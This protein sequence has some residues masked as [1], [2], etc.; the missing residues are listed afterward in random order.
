MP[1]QWTCIYSRYGSLIF[2]L[3]F[4]PAPPRVK[5][6]FTAWRMWTRPSG[7]DIHT[8][9]P[10]ALV[11]KQNKL[12][13]FS[14]MTTLFFVKTFTCDLE[15]FHG[16]NQKY[17]NKQKTYYFNQYIGL[18]YFPNHFSHWTPKKKY[19]APIFC[20]YLYLVDFFFFVH[21]K[22]EDSLIQHDYILFV[23]ICLTQVT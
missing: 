15:Y 11:V 17:G 20:Y 19:P 10:P 14:K 3:L 21:L 9:P 7:K 4:S 16:Q 2:V 18:V 5:C 12:Q 22:H 13:F 6:V 1:R 23:T 8:P